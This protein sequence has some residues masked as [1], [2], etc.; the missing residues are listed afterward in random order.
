M[1]SARL[2]SARISMCE[3]SSSS[4][5]RSSLR[6]RVSA[7]KRF[8]N[9]MAA[10]VACFL[11]EAENAGYALHHAVPALLLLGKLLPPPRSQP[12]VLGAAVVLGDAPLRGNPSCLL[13]AM[14]RRVQRSFFHTEQTVRNALD[15]ENDAIPVNRTGLGQGFQDQEIESSGK[16]VFLAHRAYLT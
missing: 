15:V 13:D 5:S 1:P 9:D 3:R 11:G 7:V 6:L 8:S 4:R 10:P 12:V 16:L 2:S 14:Q